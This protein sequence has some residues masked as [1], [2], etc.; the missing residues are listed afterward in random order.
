VDLR[1]PTADL[2]R[3]KSASQRAR[4][5]TEPW[6]AANLYCPACDSPR[7]ESLR[8]NTPAHDFRCP[9]CLGWFQLKS[10][11]SS[12]GRRVQDGAF[13]AMRR[14]I[15]EG[16]T[17]SLFLLQYKRPEL[18]VESVLLI[19]HFVFSESML[20]R[21]KPLS[22]KAERRGWVGCN[23]FLDGIPSDAR[24]YVIRD[25]DA[26]PPSKVREAYDKLRPLEK[27]KVEKRGWTLDVLK[28]VRSLGKQEF[29]LSEVYAHSEA[30]G[31]L[32]PQNRHVGEKVRQQLQVLRKL[33]ILEFVGR[34]SYRLR[35]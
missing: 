6:G 30:L 16:R 3:Y 35:A 10:K 15:V 33:G 25:G 22:S 9:S 2:D 12:F 17:P 27:L 1:L 7:I 13:D 18:I 21:R 24:I 31:K 29:L 8:A 32:H 11:S 34:G 14:T 23:F 5:S 28:V 26:T 19:P 20:E 4:V